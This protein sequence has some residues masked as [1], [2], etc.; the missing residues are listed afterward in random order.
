MVQNCRPQY[1][2]KKDVKVSLKDSP[3]KTR[4][5]TTQLLAQRL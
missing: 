2:I 5:G 3:E 4:K 1:F